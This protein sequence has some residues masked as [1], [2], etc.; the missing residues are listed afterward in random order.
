MGLPTRPCIQRTEG[1]LAARVQ[2]RAPEFHPRSTALPPSHLGEHKLRSSCCSGQNP[3]SQPH[4][5]ILS[6]PPPDRQQIPLAPPSQYDQN[7]TTSHHCTAAPAYQQDERASLSQP[8]GTPSI[9][10]PDPSAPTQ[11]R[12]R[13]FAAPKRPVAP[14]LSQ[15]EVLTLA[16]TALK[17]QPPCACLA[18]SPHS[19]TPSL[20]GSNTVFLS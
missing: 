7:L 13:P 10:L 12:S 16:L 3:W 15:G 5:A 6:P 4:P 17:L 11:V 2:A 18:L 20:C 19:L 14:H 8:R 9:R 1:I